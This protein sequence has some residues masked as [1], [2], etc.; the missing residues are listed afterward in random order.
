M[1]NNP[2][3]TQENELEEPQVVSCEQSLI[4]FG[5]KHF[6]NESFV[7]SIIADGT[8]NGHGSTIDE[9]YDLFYDYRDKYPKAEHCK[10]QLKA[11][12]ME[13]LPL[14]I[15]YIAHYIFDEIK[16]LGYTVYRALVV[17]EKEAEHLVNFAGKI[18]TVGS[19]GAYWTTNKDTFAHGFK[20]NEHQTKS[21]TLIAPLSLDSVN[22]F[23]TLRSR[24]DYVNGDDEME[25]NLSKDAKIIYQVRQ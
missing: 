11:L 16:Q 21:I 19:L 9:A 13:W 7:D 24:I 1:L 5:E 6:C 2:K 8:W 15:K 12:L 17:D 23:E 25:I 20:P 22:W 3:N 18:A 14:R 4:R 10:I